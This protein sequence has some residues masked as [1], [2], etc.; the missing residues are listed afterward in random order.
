ML[1]RSS[2]PIVSQTI[3]SRA[4]WREGGVLRCET[5]AQPSCRD[6]E[7]EVPT[8]GLLGKGLNPDS[9]ARIGAAMARGVSVEAAG[10]L[11]RRFPG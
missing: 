2:R 3:P 4:A 11:G 8:E 10:R 1:R 6:R 7:R 5:D 9:E